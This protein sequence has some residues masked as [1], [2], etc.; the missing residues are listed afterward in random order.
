MNEIP[1]IDIHTHNK[2]KAEGL[3]VFN[4]LNEENAINIEEG[5]FYSI[6]IHPW[7][8]DDMSVEMQYDFFNKY[9]NNEKVIAVGECGLDKLVKVPFEIQKEIFVYQLE[10]AQKLNKPIIIHCVRAYEEIV[11]LKKTM[12]IS[13]PMIIHGFNSSPQ[14]FDMLIKAGF[15]ISLGKAI[16][17]DDSNAAKMLA[18]SQIG[19]VFLETDDGNRSI[20]KVYEKA[21]SHL[22]LDIDTLKESIYKNYKKVFGI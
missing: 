10:M 7:Y 11:V 18:K 21:A 12:N 16:L 19:R 2:V 5:L 14:I 3:T 9:I 13:Q 17:K 8:I 1:Y 20:I 6:G 15:Y 22:K 4:I